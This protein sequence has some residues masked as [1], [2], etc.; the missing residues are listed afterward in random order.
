CGGSGGQGDGGAPAAPAA[1]RGGDVGGAFVLATRLH[2]AEPQPP[3]SPSPYLPMSRRQISPLYLRI[4]DIPEYQGLDA[5]DRAR[6]E[7]LAAPLREASGTAALIDR[8]VVWTAKRA[9][10]ELIRTVPLTARRRAELDAFL[11]RDR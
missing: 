6:V 8:D 3:V 1:G 9:A 7:A 2:A 4:E 5:G 10:A 11:A